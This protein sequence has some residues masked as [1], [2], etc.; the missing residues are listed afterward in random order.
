[1]AKHPVPGRVKTR[2]AVALGA[3]T[4]CALSR[5]FILD[6]A[7]RLEGLP[8]AVTW[9]YWPPDAPFAAL[10]PGASCRAQDG[11][12]RGARMRNAVDAA[13]AAGAAAVIVLGADVPHVETA[14]LAE[15]AAALAAGADV[16]LG[17]ARDGGYYLIALRAP[18][19]ALFERIA[20]GTPAVFEATR[21]RAAAA[22]L[23][24]LVLPGTFDVDAPADLAALRALVAGGRSD[25]PHTARLLA[26]V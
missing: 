24:V 14:V 2:L 15:A 5:A 26:R 13:L 7:A 20:W 22:G 4:A 17:P 12:D 6:L 19:P 23:Q 18:Q 10:L 3:E 16:A 21:D 9:A 25:L 1:M 11:D 8:Y